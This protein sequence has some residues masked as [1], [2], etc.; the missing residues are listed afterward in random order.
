MSPILLNPFLGAAAPSASFTTVAAALNPTAW[1][2]LNDASA[3]TTIADNSGNSH[4]GTVSSGVTFQQTGLVTG[5]SD[6][7][8]SFSGS[9]VN[10]QV[11]YGTWMDAPTAVSV[12]A[13][14][15]TSHASGV[16]QIMSRDNNATGARVWQFRLNSGKPEIVKIPGQV[17]SAAGPSSIADGAVHDVG[18][19]YDGSNLRL[20]VDGAKVARTFA[21]QV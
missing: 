1:Y 15:K 18:A 16:M 2:R 20:Y 14:I 4:G 6:K 11:A 9:T 7:C 8:A 3:S 10:S 13:I 12:F 21:S 19:T 17:V 5:D